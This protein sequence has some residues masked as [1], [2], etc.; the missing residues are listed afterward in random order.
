MH[1]ARVP[2][3]HALALADVRPLGCIP[4]PRSAVDGCRNQLL[5]VRRKCH[6]A[7]ATAVSLPHQ[8]TMAC[9][10]VPNSDGLVLATGGDLLGVG[11]EACRPQGAL[12]ALQHALALAAPGRRR[13]PDPRGAVVRGRDD[14]PAGGPEGGAAD[15]AG[16]ALE[17]SEA[18]TSFQTPYPSCTVV[19][20]AEQESSVWRKCNRPCV[21]IVPF[22]HQGTLAGGAIKNTHQ[23]VA[24]AHGNLP[25][26]NREVDGTC[27]ALPRVFQPERLQAS[28]LCQVPEPRRAV[29]RCGDQ[30]QAGRAEGNGL[31]CTP[32]AP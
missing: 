29:P 3:Q 9:E 6:R 7:N 27:S 18:L 12:V 30:Q 25:P 21:P 4:K 8:Q 5:P 26:V 22:E 2:L 11:C 13:R 1:A 31:H 10:H 16:V 14:A 20:A 24:V 32:V 15:A 23:A 19:G 28:A 17:H